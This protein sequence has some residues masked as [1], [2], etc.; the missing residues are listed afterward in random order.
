LQNFRPFT[1]L[2]ALLLLLAPATADSTTKEGFLSDIKL[3]VATQN[4]D[5]M[6]SLYY[7]AGSPPAFT[8][9]LKEGLP[10][11][12]SWLKDVTKIDYSTKAAAEA[13]PYARDGSLWGPNLPVL[14]NVEI[15][16][17]TGL[18]NLAYGQKDGRFYLVGTKRVGA[19][20]TADV[21]R[22]NVLAYGRSVTATL[23][24]EPLPISG[25]KSEDLAITPWL[26]KGKN[27]LVIS[28]KK[29]GSEANM[30]DGKATLS[31]YRGTEPVSE[32]EAALDP[33]PGTK[34][35]ELNI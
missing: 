33:T 8:S 6:Y 34:T 30:L 7:L 1:T 17:K 28:W 25:G 29:K 23:N 26:K 14:G 19:A 2:I 15:K 13:P 5:L 10:K 18:T 27:V 3:A 35:F 32:E 20:A 16:T 4:A 22:L 12:L 31:R 9:E 11:Q 21:V 24:G